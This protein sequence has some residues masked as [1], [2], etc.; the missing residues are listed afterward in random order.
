LFLL[1]FSGR[2]KLS[3]SRRTHI[4]LSQGDRIHHPHHGIGKVQSIRR[5]SFSG[6]NG[7]RFAEIF[8]QRERIT[9]MVRENSLDCTVRAPIGPSRAEKL[10]Q[11]MKD[12]KG[13]VSNQWKTRANKHQAM[14][15]DGAPRAYAEVYKNLRVREQ[16]D[17]LSA[18]DRKHLQRCTEFLAEELANALDMPRTEALDQMAEV[19]RIE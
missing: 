4:T 10:L 1:L 8:F 5:R 3:E 16:E 14:M 19:T 13:K 18:A 7:S 11:H 2:S 9:L 17:A 6:N 15:D 12:W